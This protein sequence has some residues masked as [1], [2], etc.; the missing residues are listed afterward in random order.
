MLRGQGKFKRE[1][2]AIGEVARVLGVPS[3]TLR[4]W[5]R[6]YGLVTTARTPGGHR[7]YTAEDVTRLR[8]M[9]ELLERGVGPATAS[10]WAIEGLTE[11]GVVGPALDLTNPI[12]CR[13]CGARSA[14]CRTGSS[15]VVLR[16]HP[17]IRRSCVG[18]VRRAD[19]VRT[20]GCAW[21]RRTC[22]VRPAIVTKDRR[23]VARCHRFFAAQTDAADPSGPCRLYGGL[24]AS[25]SAPSG[26]R[27]A[28]PRGQPRTSTDA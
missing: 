28:R 18:P 23:R 10:R 22:R 8:I 9:I 25:P 24:V 27:R 12:R 2:L 26:L 11:L 6:R 4:T 13:R 20:P 21:T 14:G 19:E 3:P 15:V 1:G 5:Q 7:R 16:R 17:P